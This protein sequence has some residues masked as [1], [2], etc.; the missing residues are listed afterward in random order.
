M[1]DEHEMEKVP[2]GPKVGVGKGGLMDPLEGGEAD[3]VSRV[4][5]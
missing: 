4:R 1:R 5:W 2:P 3:M